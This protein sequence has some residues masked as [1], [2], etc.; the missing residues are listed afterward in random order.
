[1]KKKKHKNKKWGYDQNGHLHLLHFDRASCVAVRNSRQIHDNI[2]VKLLY[3]IQMYM[4]NTGIN[5]LTK[6]FALI[7]VSV[8]YYPFS[9]EMVLVHIGGGNYKALKNK[10]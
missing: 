10:Q 8:Y 4:N 2:D 9:T 1:M 5:P 3:D 7:H 6:A